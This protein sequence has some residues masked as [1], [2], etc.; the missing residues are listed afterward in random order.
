MH[1]LTSQKCGNALWLGR[2]RRHSSSHC[3]TVVDKRVGA[4]QTKL[5]DPSLVNKC[6]IVLIIAYMLSMAFYS[7]EFADIY[8]HIWQF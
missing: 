7:P 2:K 5:R 3:G 6:Q 4:W 1:T 8:A